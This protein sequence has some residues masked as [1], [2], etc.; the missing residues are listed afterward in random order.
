MT[1]DF[2]DI[3]RKD[4]YKFE[5]GSTTRSNNYVLKASDFVRVK[6]WSENRERHI[7]N[8]SNHIENSY[9]YIL[10]SIH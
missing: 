4:D 6:C 3:L 8:E 10:F 2:T 7:S 1:C 9:K 5:Y